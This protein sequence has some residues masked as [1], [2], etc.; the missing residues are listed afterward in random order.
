MYGC[1]DGDMRSVGGSFA[2]DFTGGQNSRRQLRNLGRDVQ[3]WQILDDLEPLTCC[4]GVSCAGFVNDKLR[5]V[6]LESV[7]SLFPPFPCDLLVA[8]NDQIP[9][10]PRSQVARNGCLQV[11]AGLHPSILTKLELKISRASVYR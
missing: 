11:Q 9:A 1:C 6:N 5:N 7:P 4:D 10:R 3:Q 2:R 8:R